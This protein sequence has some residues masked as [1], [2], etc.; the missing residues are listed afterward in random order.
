MK[1]VTWVSL[2][3]KDDR[4][5]PVPTRPQ[6]RSQ[7]VTK[8]AQVVHLLGRRFNAVRPSSVVGGFVG[9]SKL[10]MCLN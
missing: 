4:L 10:N 8:I 6:S 2:K 1:A 7:E 3:V 9:S 5:R